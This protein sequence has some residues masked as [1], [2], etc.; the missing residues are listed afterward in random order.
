[1]FVQHWTRTIYK[2]HCTYCGKEYE[3]ETDS[4]IPEKCECWVWRNEVMSCDLP[5]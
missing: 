3:V 5:F 2:I 1:M 4:D